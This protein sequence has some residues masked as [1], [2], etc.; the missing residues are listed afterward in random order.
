MAFRTPVLFKFAAMMGLLAGLSACLPNARP[1]KSS[2]ATSDLSTLVTDAASDGAKAPCTR[3]DTST[4]ARSVCVSCY[5]SI[6][7]TRCPGKTEFA[8]CLDTTV[9]TGYVTLVNQCVS[10]STQAGFTCTTTCGAGLVVNPT[11]CTCVAAPPVSGGGGANVDVGQTDFGPPIIRASIPSNAIV[12]TYVSAT[13]CEGTL[14][15]YMGVQNR[16]DTVFRLN[17]YS[18]PTTTSPD[19]GIGVPYLSN[20]STPSVM[21]TTET[22]EHPGTNI[23]ASVKFTTA[24]VTAV[25]AATGGRV[26][27]ITTVS[28]SGS[29]GSTF[30]DGITNGT[31]G[32][33][34]AIADVTW[35]APGFSTR[36]KV[37]NVYVSDSLANVVDVICYQPVSVGGGSPFCD[38]IDQGKVVRIAGLAGQAGYK[39]DTDGDDIEEDPSGKSGFLFKLNSPHGLAVD[40]TYSV[41]IADSGNHIVRRVD[42]V[43]KFIF[44]IAGTAK[45]P[46]TAASGFN[47]PYGVDIDTTNNF[48][49]FADYQNHRITRCPYSNCGGGPF[50]IV[51]GNGSAGYK[52]DGARTTTDAWM[53]YPTDIKVNWYGNVLY[54]D[55]RNHLIRGICFFTGMGDF[56]NTTAVGNVV[57]VAGQPPN[58]AGVPQAGDSGEGIAANRGLITFP[59]QLLIAKQFADDTAAAQS[60]TALYRDNNIIFTEKLLGGTLLNGVPEPSTLKNGTGTLN[61]ISNLHMG[62]NHTCFLDSN[63]A[64]KCVGNNSVNQIGIS[65]ANNPQ[66]TPLANGVTISGS[67]LIGGGS[68]HTCAIS[69]DF[70]SIQCWGFNGSGQLGNGTTSTQ[71]DAVP[72]S[73]GL[74][75]PANPTWSLLSGGDNHTCAIDIHNPTVTDRV[76]CWGNNSSGQLGLGAGNFTSETQPTLKAPLAGLGADA[77]PQWIVASGNFTCLSYTVTSGVLKY[78]VACWGDDSKGQLGTDG[79]AQQVATTPVKDDSTAVTLEGDDYFKVAAGG[80]HACAWTFGGTDLLYCWGSNSKGELGIGKTSASEKM[81]HQI[82]VNG[83][84]LPGDGNSTLGAVALGIAHTC[85]VNDTFQVFCWGDNSSGQLGNDDVPFS[86]VPLQVVGLPS[87][88]ISGIYAGGNQTCALYSTGIPYCWGNNQ[89]KQ[90]GTPTA[91]TATPSGNVVRI[92]C[93]N[94][95]TTDNPTG[96][97]RTAGLC[98]GVPK[99]SLAAGVTTVTTAQGNL[100]TIAGKSG[101]AGNRGTGDGGNAR[102][103]TIAK[104]VGLTYDLYKNIIIS[105]GGFKDSSGN[106]HIDFSL[107]R[108]ANV[109]VGPSSGVKYTVTDSNNLSSYWCLRLKATTV[110][111]STGTCSC[112]MLPPTDDTTDPEFWKSVTSSAVC[113]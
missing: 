99:P 6:L 51:T 56:C 74:V 16:G 11:N 89:N 107:R 70:T 41:Y 102:S 15:I 91:S 98:T 20:A 36:D 32:P 53:Q 60:G 82:T 88:T 19:N 40:S 38:G 97:I 37:G 71:I 63:G 45:I 23:K 94:N 76:W 92:I 83:T 78:R 49:Y 43:S 4:A 47:F 72:V 9:K 108:I 31:A 96:D 111:D 18:F 46:S 68:N 39:T 113:Q 35:S 84:L 7:S 93:G 112:A 66:S 42:A 79:V 87:G 64:V 90:L 52:A 1:A 95:D 62:V 34:N 101:K 2:A 61:G 80:T 73:T 44:N 50:E 110:C 103:A 21:T 105:S 109:V 33:G 81:A 17:G 27:V 12:G 14:P 13:S 58:T 3:Y 57:T 48:I 22:A 30:S 29:D 75:V 65:T 69:S 85:Y 24:G 67:L 59:M 77:T 106:D 100:Y 104:A 5:Q 86:T 8:S 28:G 26:G 10:Q 55:S 54:T 25:T